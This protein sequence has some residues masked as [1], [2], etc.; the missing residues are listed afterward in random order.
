MKS[1]VIGGTRGFG[2][3]LSDQLLDRG[4]DLI[5]VSRSASGYENRP[6]YSCDVGDLNSWHETLQRIK[7]EY[8]TLDFLACVAGFT[9]AK[10]SKDLTIDDWSQTLSKNVTYVALALQELSN[11][12][13]VSN[14]PRALTIGSQWSYKN[15]CDELVPYTVSKHA[16]RAL[17]EDF[18]QR[19]QRIQINHYCVPTMDTPGY[20]EVRKSFQNAGEASTILSFTPEGLADPKV[21]AK[22]IV[23][24]ALET[25]ASGSTFIIKPDGFIE[26]L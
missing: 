26:K 3:E 17:T 5:T 16:L 2:K 22:A 19:N 9:R 10:F 6:H 20:W 1:L 7:S 4:Y 15:G 23:D 18:A 8:D 25:D 12:L 11:L 21:V 13:H 14:H 24:R